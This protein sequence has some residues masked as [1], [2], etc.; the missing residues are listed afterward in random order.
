[1]KESFLANQVTPERTV[2]HTYNDTGTR[3]T[4]KDDSRGTTPVS[5]ELDRADR[6]TKITQP[7]NQ[8]VAYGYNTVGN[9]TIM[10]T[11]VGSDIRTVSYGYDLVNR[12]ETVNTSG[13]NRNAKFFYDYAGKRTKF[14]LPNNTEAQYGY[15]DLN[16]NN[17]VK[18]YV[19]GNST[20]FASYVY[21][22]IGEGWN[23]TKLTEGDGSVTNWYYDDMYR[24]K[25]EQRTGGSGSLSWDMQY[26]YD[27]VGNRKQFVSGSQTTDYQYNALDQLTVMTQTGG[28]VTNYAYNIRGNLSTV[29]QGS[30]TTTYG[31]DAADRLI[32]AAT[33]GNSLSFNY[34]PPTA[35]CRSLAARTPQT[36]CG[37]SNRRMAM[38]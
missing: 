10:T 26:S 25:R 24:L 27:K 17:S 20:P 30:N 2:D 33:G 32:S 19:T 18:Y 1:V 37:M 12:L 21:E 31:W 9:R 13:Y 15:D 22:Y 6:V 36:I 28:V 16:R 5:Y 11:T 3:L 34:D 38:C 35:G 23:K 14:E 7:G 4:A 8:N 29:T